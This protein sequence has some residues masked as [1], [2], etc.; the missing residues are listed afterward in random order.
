LVNHLSNIFCPHLS[1]RM[2]TSMSSTS[3]CGEG[4]NGWT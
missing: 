1:A 4:S 3:T 2:S